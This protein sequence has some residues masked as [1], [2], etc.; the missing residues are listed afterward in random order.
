MR[1]I[2]IK[3]V[4]NTVIISFAA[5]MLASGMSFAETYSDWNTIKSDVEKENPVTTININTSNIDTNNTT[6]NLGA[7]PVPG[8]GNTYT[9][10]GAQGG[11][12][13]NAGGQGITTPTTSQIFV[14][15]GGTTTNITNVNFENG[16]GNSG[17]AIQNATSIGSGAGYSA[18]GTMVIGSDSYTT[19]FEGNYAG[20]GGA[21]Y[22][23][24]DI[25]INNAEFSD[26]HA[27]EGSNTDPVWSQGGNNGRGGA[28]FNGM[29]NIAEGNLTI[30]NS[31]FID[32]SS[33]GSGTSSAFS[34]VIHNRDGSL[35]INSSII[36]EK[37]ND[38]I[39][40]NSAT[41][42]G[43][44]IVNQDYAVINDSSISYNSA[45]SLGGAILNGLNA[46]ATGFESNSELHLNNTVLSHNF[47]Q[48]GGGAV[49]N[50]ADNQAGRLNTVY[51]NNG[52]AFLDNGYNQNSPD[53]ITTTGGAIYNA[54]TMGADSSDAV[55]E[56]NTSGDTQNAVIFQNNIATS[57]GAINNQGVAHVNNTIFDSNGT[58][59]AVAN[60]TITTSGGA[61]YNANTAGGSAG[62]IDITNSTFTNNVASNGGAIYNS[63]SGSGAIKATVNITDTDFAGNKAL[64]SAGTVVAENGGAI[65][66]ANN[67]VTNIKAVN[68]DVNIGEYGTSLSNNNDTIK[69]AGN[70][71][72]NLAAS[73]NN[74]INLNSS[75]YGDLRTN[76]INA[77]GGRINVNAPIKNSTISINDGMMKFEH[78]RYLA[79]Q[80]TAATPTALNNIVLNGGTL[81]VLNGE[82][83]NQ[84]RG[85]SFAVKQNS[86]IMLDVDLHNQQMDSIMAANFGGDG[87][88]TLEN[89]SILNISSMKSFSEAQGTSALIQFTDATA[90]TDHVTNK[91]A[92]VIEA[93]IYNYRVTHITQ[94]AA[95]GRPLGGGYSDGEYFQFDRLGNS[96]SSLVTP[97]AA[98]AAFLIQDNLYRQ[99]FANMDMVTLMSP[100]E[101]MAWKMRNKYANAGYHTGVYA[102][103]IIPEERDGFYVRPFTNFENV[104]LKNGPK[105]SN[106]SYGMLIGGESDIVDLGH[107]WDGNFSIFGAYHGSHQAYNGVGIWQNGG[108]LGAVGTAYKGNFWTGVTANIG[109]S[110]AEAQTTFG[111]DGFPILM[112]GAAWKS[113]YNWGLLNNKLII[114]PSYMMSYTFV[115]VFDYTNSAGVRI[116]QD[117]LHAIEIIPGLRIIGNLKN[118]WQPYIGLNMTWNIMDKTKFYANEVPLTPLSI[119]PYFEY[120][121]GLQKRYG[122]RFTGFGQAMLRNGGRN[123]IAFT[124][125]FRWALGH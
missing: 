59:E 36:G 21:I 14:N 110:A 117:P 107:G 28:I 32:N 80:E 20:R 44:A 17:G 34:G 104:P 81:N 115:N 76:V 72:L 43:G 71:E 19:K 35:T 125:G 94:S 120:G 63:T 70:A 122:D 41:T 102:P 116:T 7:P 26:N 74:V 54:G 45:G 16:V 24:G 118:G 48:S 61:I 92:E 90:L 77:N 29:E 83:G 6:I 62:T 86:D 64:N 73:N 82:L 100:E 47:A 51:V 106:V 88:I 15:N 78:D 37:V 56:I 39:H 3:K 38:V 60:G 89:D 27:Y 101:R 112:T 33:S 49:M 91:G 11:T 18:G 109:A 108:T 79:G 1:K 4:K 123:G 69:L 58:N 124:L 8:S 93:P 103:N 119:K 84:I 85:A 31:K 98:Q 13:I 113:G 57:G 66:A 53:T 2:K 12:T 121:V 46:K 75:I 9:V 5:I 52:T 67:T 96:D 97:V 10:T 23:L 25:T 22:N 50:S 68:K 42:S 30:N 105:V 40:G 111:N 95:S 65:Y 87:N 114:Q 55:L 99:S